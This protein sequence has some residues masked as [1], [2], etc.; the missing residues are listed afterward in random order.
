M[1]V[2]LLKSIA[3]GTQDRTTLNATI[4]N[5]KRNLNT[6]IKNL[7]YIKNKPAIIIQGR[8]DIVC[9]IISADKLVNNWPGAQY[10]IL[11]DAGHSALEPGIKRELVLATEMMKEKC[12]K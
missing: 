9:P 2:R 12:I 4:Q 1:L 7:H 5:L 10:K 8:Y 6:I 3:N 11:T